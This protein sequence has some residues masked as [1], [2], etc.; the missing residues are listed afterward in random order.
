M[1]RTILILML[2]VPALLW[3][4]APPTAY[5]EKADRVFTNAGQM[6][7]LQARQLMIDLVDAEGEP[8]GEQELIPNPSFVKYRNTAS[9]AWSKDGDDWEVVWRLKGVPA[10]EQV[11]A[12]GVSSCKPLERQP[13]YIRVRIEEPS[14]KQPVDPA[15]EVELP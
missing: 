13:I 10:S 7:E 1:K 9:R 8:T 3:A 2:V 14:F 11:M 4:Y 15:L 5:V 12:R 6:V